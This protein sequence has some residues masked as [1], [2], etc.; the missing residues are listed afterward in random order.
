LKNAD[1]QELFELPG[2][3]IDLLPVLMDRT[4]EIANSLV[5]GIVGEARREMAAHLEGEIVRL[6]ELKKVN[7]TVRDEEMELLVQQQRGLDE[8]L[9]NARLRLDALRVILRGGL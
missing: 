1:G 8:Y 4:E 9:S 5:P 3:R 7:R 2:L 6:R